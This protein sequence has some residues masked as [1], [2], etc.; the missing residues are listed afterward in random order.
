MAVAAKEVAEATGSLRPIP[1]GVFAQGS[2]S[3]A[4]AEVFSEALLKNKLYTLLPTPHVRQK[5]SL[6]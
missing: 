5:K 3:A 2:T 1:F 6:T 4:A